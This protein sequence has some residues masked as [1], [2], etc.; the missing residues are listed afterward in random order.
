MTH[1]FLLS[2]I[3]ST[4]LIILTRFLHNLVEASIDLYPISRQP[5]IYNR[6]VKIS[7]FKFVIES[8]FE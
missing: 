1:E 3:E 2:D 8:T 6:S 7:I 4:V 5:D